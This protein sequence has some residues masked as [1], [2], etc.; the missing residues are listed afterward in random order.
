MRNTAVEEE[1][2]RAPRHL[3]DQIDEYL[4]DEL[5]FVR[6]KERIKSMIIP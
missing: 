6:E 5:L 2:R 4:Y 1:L 3:P